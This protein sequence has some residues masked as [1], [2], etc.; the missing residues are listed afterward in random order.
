[1]GY[2]LIVRYQIH[3]ISTHHGLAWIQ[4]KDEPLNFYDSTSKNLNF[5]GNLIREAFVAIGRK[6]PTTKK[7]GKK[8]YYMYQCKFLQFFA[9]ISSVVPDLWEGVQLLH[10][11]PVSLHLLQHQ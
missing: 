7:T 3:R 5:I 9:F 11:I 2:F 10:G 4:D 8:L 6:N 1:M